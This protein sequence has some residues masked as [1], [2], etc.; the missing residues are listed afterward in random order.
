MDNNPFSS[1][2]KT[3]R[4]DNRTQKKVHFRMGTVL[5]VAPLKIEVAGI[6]QDEKALLKN[7][8]ITSFAPGDRLLLFPI[9]EEQRYIIICKVVKP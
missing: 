6:E 2:V 5:S 1:V 9:E 8:L 7:D 4:E 3:I